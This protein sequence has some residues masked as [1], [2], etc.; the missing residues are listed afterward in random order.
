[1]EGLLPD[2]TEKQFDTASADQN[3]QT[4]VM[5]AHQIAARVK[6]TGNKAIGFNIIDLNIEYG[7]CRIWRFMEIQ[8]CRRTC[9][10]PKLELWSNVGIWKIFIQYVGDTLNMSCI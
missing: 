8:P 1:M 4:I 7:L 5:V 9:L 6:E 3:S 10:S 2:R